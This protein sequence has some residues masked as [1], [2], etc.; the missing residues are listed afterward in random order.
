[1]FF[2]KFGNIISSVPGFIMMQP[3]V[4]ALYISA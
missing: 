4:P 3:F 2:L 1:M